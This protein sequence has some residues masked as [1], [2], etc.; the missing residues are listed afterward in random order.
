MRT[1]TRCNIRKIGTMI[2][3]PLLYLA[4]EENLRYDLEENGDH[5][6]KGRTFPFHTLWGGGRRPEMYYRSELV[7]LIDSSLLQNFSQESPNRELF[8][9]ICHVCSFMC[10]HDPRE[11]KIVPE[12][13][14]SAT[15][16]CL[17]YLNT[18]NLQLPEM[19]IIANPGFDSTFDHVCKF[20]D[21]F[22]ASGHFRGS[23][24]VLRY[25]SI[26]RDIKFTFQLQQNLA[27]R[28]VQ[29]AK[30]RDQDWLFVNQNPDQVCHFPLTYEDCL[31]PDYFVLPPQEFV[32]GSAQPRA[33]FL[34]RDKFCCSM[35][36]TRGGMFEPA[37]LTLLTQREWFTVFQY[38]HHGQSP[39]I[40]KLVMLI[41]YRI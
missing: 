36:R 9:R 27:S 31:T 39:W 17:N 41:I 24:T 1:R 14:V 11:R 38:K 25:D 10:A 7:S 30:S 13:F 22:C 20:I 12:S 40:I 18:G 35:D 16:Q 32:S 5:N 4:C 3:W 29:Y 33:I 19:S 23:A 28:T 15:E 34:P 2:L 6:Y 37:F 21:T 8:E 26:S